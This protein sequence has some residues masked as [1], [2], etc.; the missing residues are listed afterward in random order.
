MLTNLVAVVVAVVPGALL[1]SVLP[2]GRYRWAAWASAP[3]LT[4][5]LTSVAMGWLP[6]LGLPHSATAVLVAELVLA[7][8]AVLASRLVRRDVP[9][10]EEKSRRPW[11]HLPA[12]RPRRADLIGIT[13]PALIT[14]GY[15]WLLLGRLAA[16]PGWDAMHHGYF[17]RRI[18]E[19][20]SATIASACSTSLDSIPTCAF[21]PI[22]ANVSW[23]QAAQLSGG[24]IS[25]AM[26]TWA[27]VIGPLALVA[28]VYACVRA[29]D[30]GPVVAACAA[31]AP[32]F[33]G[34]LWFSVVVGRITQQAGPSM[35]AGTALLAAL[36][37]RG[38]HPVRLGLLAGLASA[39]LVMSHT[40]DI[41]FVGVLALALLPLLRGP[42]TLT[43]LRTAA[44]A[45][46]AGRGR[47]GKVLRASIAGIGAATVA[48][49]VA[50]G[51][52]LSALIGANGERAAYGPALPG[53]LG[54]AFEYW[55]VDP[56]RYVLFGFPSPGGGDFQ[57]RVRT[58]QIALVLTIACLL[59]SPLCLVLRQLRWSRP[60]LL[61]GVVMTGI[62]IWTSTS[63]SAAAALVSSLWYGSRERLRFLIFPVYGLLA[64][65]GAIA[66]GLV[67]QWLLTKLVA[68]TQTL[69]D[70]TTPAAIAASVL[71][72]S[73]ALLAAV[74]SSWRPLR[75]HFK[76]LAPVGQ[77]YA[78][79]FQ[80]LTEKTTPGKAIAYDRRQ[81]LAWSYVDYG[82]PALF[83]LEPVPA[84]EAEYYTPRSQAWDWLV[85]NE[86]AQPG[87]CQVRRFDVE[88]VVV[89]GRP[90]LDEKSHYDLDRLAASDR[91]TL[92]HQMDTFK[93]YRVTEAGRACAAVG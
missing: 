55:V 37:V 70:S 86:G 69:Q 73:L 74:P 47:I 38:H 62:G 6:A 7:G 25:S 35:A 91:L 76:G 2:P 50:I 36:A 83:G 81:Y 42:R 79:I 64:V 53:Q 71:V 54:K 13:V 87:G 52:F 92:V 4:L 27:I 9:T 89:G 93:V 30:G 66:I 29:L 41:L 75:T 85:N 63:K 21:Y 67:V 10:D 61:T 3:A 16:P 18:L 90:M 49:L 11:F 68:R 5:G 19:T 28:T 33:L 60:W 15:G 80:W 34:P 26:I 1:G 22:A 57:L 82:V 17:T 44:R 88:Y 46:W 43:D 45:S 51:P 8:A 72:L 56:Q 48:G 78:R 32:T 14:V 39:G 23:A 59:A 20:G 31:A 65:A 40:Y 24:H 77:S 12:V 84:F 58:I